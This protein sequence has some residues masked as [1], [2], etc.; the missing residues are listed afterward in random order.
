M[1]SVGL[2]LDRETNQIAYYNPF[3]TTYFGAKVAG[4]PA[5]FENGGFLPKNCVSIFLMHM[6]DILY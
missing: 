1:Y 6:L 5:P 4:T 2:H 3:T